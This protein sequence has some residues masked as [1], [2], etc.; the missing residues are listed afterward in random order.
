MRQENIQKRTITRRNQLAINVAIL[1]GTALG[2]AWPLFY[3]SFCTILNIHPS[4]AMLD[5]FLYREGIMPLAIIGIGA[6]SLV[7]WLIGAWRG[8]SEAVLDERRNVF[9]G[10]LIAV[11]FMLTYIM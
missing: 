5:V 6:V 1:I 9:I 10:C 4:Q 2:G 7:S 8:T 11:W 3:L